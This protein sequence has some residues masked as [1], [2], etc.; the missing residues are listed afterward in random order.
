MS[1]S[2]TFAIAPH[3][4]RGQTLLVFALCAGFLMLGLLALVGDDA[5]LQVRYNRIDEA[6]VLA[7]QAAS[8]DIDVAVFISNHRLQLAGDAG[9]VCADVARLNEPQ[10]AQTS[11]YLPPDRSYVR[12]DTSDRTSFFLRLFGSAFTVRASH[13][14]RPAYGL[15]HPCTNP[16]DPATC[17]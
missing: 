4:Q 14:G 3:N 13:V 17:A 9:Q 12:A 11:C 15:T 5:I 6:S 7:A 1:P 8:S 16:A 10:G 2:G